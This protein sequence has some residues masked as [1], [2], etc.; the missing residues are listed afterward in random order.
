MEGDELIYVLLEFLLRGPLQFQA[1]A[2]QLLNLFAIQFDH[3]HS[4]L[5]RAQLRG[6]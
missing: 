5:S 1:M 4:L 6:E 3:V 2:A